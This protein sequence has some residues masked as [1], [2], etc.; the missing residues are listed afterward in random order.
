MQPPVRAAVGKE[1]KR[2]PRGSGAYPTTPI[3]LPPELVEALDRY[4]AKIKS[5]RSAV[6]RQ[7]IEAG[8]KRPPKV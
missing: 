5:N 6:M 4:A 8:L 2:R 7:F 3:R 1:R